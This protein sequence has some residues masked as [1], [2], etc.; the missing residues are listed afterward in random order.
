MRKDVWLIEALPER[1]PADDGAVEQNR[2]SRTLF[3]PV[4]ETSRC[5]FSNVCEH[6]LDDQGRRQIVRNGH[7]AAR[8]IVTPM[9]P[10]AIA[11]PLCKG[12][13]A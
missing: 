5:R 12:E 11:I 3:N 1:P 7:A 8:T 4:V 2:G 10:M 9:G 13:R 6:L